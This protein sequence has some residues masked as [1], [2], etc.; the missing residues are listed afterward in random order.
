MTK[1]RFTPLDAPDWKRA[2]SRML[3]LLYPAYC[4]LCRASLKH[5]HA[6]CMECRA[7]LPPIA[8]PFCESCGEAF[9]GKIDGPFECPNCSGLSFSFEFAR[10]ALLRDDRTL[11]LIHRLKYGREIHLARELGCLAEAAFADP[12]LAP[13]LEG[14]WPLVPVPLHRSRLR[15]RH[16]NQAEEIALPLSRLTSCPVL[17]ALRRIRSTDTQTLLTRRQRMDNLRGAFSITRSGRDFITRQPAGAVIIDDVLTTGSTVNECARTLRKAGFKKIFVVT[18][19]R[20]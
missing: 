17:H 15:E 7:D 5:G 10:P 14:G 16:F 8:H 6:L 1:G 11:D 13:A 2:V 19:M 18:V 12:R 4:A 3:D 9:F 20:G